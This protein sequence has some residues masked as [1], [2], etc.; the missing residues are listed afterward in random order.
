MWLVLL[1]AEQILACAGFARVQGPQKPYPKSDETVASAIPD[2]G[3]AMRFR[4][5]A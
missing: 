4:E 3:V 5:A 1:S 2:Q